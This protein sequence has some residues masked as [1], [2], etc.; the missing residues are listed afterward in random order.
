MAVETEQL[1]VQLEARIRDFERN[2]QRAN[3]TASSNWS[4]MERRGRQA[5]NRMRAD[6]DRASAGIVASVRGM[7]AGI[8]RAL[9][10]GGLGFTALGA[11]ARGLVGSLAEVR[12]AADRAGVSSEVFQELAYAARLS[13]VP[14][15]AMANG[16]RE[17]QIRADEFATTMG[18]PG[19]DA[20]ARIGLSPEETRARLADPAA[21][22]TE[23]IRRVQTLDRAAQIRVFDEIFGGSAG[24]QFIRFLDGGAQGLVNLRTEAH[25]VGAVLNDEVL[26][27]AETLDRKFAQLATTVEQGLKGAIVGAADWLRYMLDLMNSVEDRSMETLRSQLTSA[28]EAYTAWMNSALRATIGDGALTDN[29][30]LNIQE[31]TRE[32]VRRENLARTTLPDP[33]AGTPAAGATTPAP[34]GT[35]PTTPVTPWTP[36]ATGGGG[37]GAGAIRLQRDAVEELIQSLEDELALIG[38]S[39][40]EQ[41]I[42]SE[43]RS[44]GA[45]ATDEQ[46]D[47]IAALVT[48]IEE[49]RASVERLEEAMANLGDGAREV[50]GGVIA[51]LRAGKS[52]ADILASALDRIVSRLANTAIDAFVNAITGALSAGA[53]GGF[54]ILR[55]LLG[56]AEGGMVRGPGTGTSDSVLARLSDGEFV[57]NAA[58]TARYRPLLEA[59]NENRLP[60]FARGGA[61]SAGS[62]YTRGDTVI[63]LAPT[64]HVNAVG[65]STEQNAEL[66]R[67]I[68]KEVETSMR[69]IATEELVRQTRPGGILYR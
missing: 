29:L 19:A 37:A 17:L 59:V 24:E 47:R 9:G 45:D 12:A 64:I 2:F 40:I 27:R 1:V 7:G 68:G 35:T 69:R 60:S 33:P 66:A 56:F 53:S 4:D 15:D 44:A 57:V 8:T 14:V 26:A 34:A 21:L 58:A 32:I 22:L 61:V 55:R 23:I 10:V 49:E 39:E 13:R 16:I 41:R 28:R 5:G 62:S 67:Q 54:P 11:A 3:R 52:G 63:A 6:M 43:V 20:F 36:P 31:I 25:N 46:R 18:G 51:D 48:A 30:F 42:L 50:L 65:G 38:A